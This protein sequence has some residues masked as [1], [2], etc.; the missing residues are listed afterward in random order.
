[1]GSLCVAKAA[2]SAC[3]DSSM[4]GK[5]QAWRHS[6]ASKLMWGQPSMNKHDNEQ[7]KRSSSISCCEQVRAFRADHLPDGMASG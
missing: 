6:H 2:L 3:T 1:M 7:G 4:R 5:C